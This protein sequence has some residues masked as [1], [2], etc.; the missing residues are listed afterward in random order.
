[1]LSGI[2]GFYY[3]KAEWLSYLQYTIPLKYR[4]EQFPLAI[5]RVYAILKL[6]VSYFLSGQNNLVFVSG[7]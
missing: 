5:P 2:N 1:M 3:N 4:H 7:W 6:F